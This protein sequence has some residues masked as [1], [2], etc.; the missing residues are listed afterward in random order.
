MEE[1]NFDKGASVRQNSDKKADAAKRYPNEQDGIAE[2]AC[3]LKAG[4]WPVIWPWVAMDL[5]GSLRVQNNVRKL[6]SDYATSVEG[7]H[8]QRDKEWQ[9]IHRTLAYD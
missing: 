6:C 4:P 2:S 9:T 5:L 7:G 3:M 1:K 8:S